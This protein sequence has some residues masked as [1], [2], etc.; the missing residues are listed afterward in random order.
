M[1]PYRQYLFFAFITR[2]AFAFSFATYVMFLLSKGATL[3]DVSFINISFMVAI[4]LSELPTGIF[5]DLLGR[6]RSFLISSLVMSAGLMIYFFSQSFWFFILAEVIAGIGMTFKS[7]AL[8]AWVVDAVAQ[9][10]GR[11]STEKIFSSG[12]IAENAANIVGGLAGAYMGQQNLAYPFLAGS[13]LLIVA[14]GLS[15]KLMI[16]PEPIAPAKIVSPFMAIKGIIDR[17]IK[18]GLKKKIVLLLMITTFM[19]SFFY[20][21]LNM[22]WQP[23]FAEMASGDIWIL[24]WIS[25][26]LMLGNYIIKKLP[27]SMPPNISLAI[28]SIFNSLPIILA[29]LFAKF[30]VVLILFCTYEVARGVTE[31]LRTAFLNRHIPSTER[32]TLLSLNQVFLRIGAV[33]GLY[34]TGLVADRLSIQAAWIVAS[35]VVLLTVPMFIACKEKR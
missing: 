17:S 1:K 32:A 19:T 26:S 31:P 34:I 20:Q 11:I 29:A 5:A 33:L 30:Y 8:E 23:R 13:I 3:L 4:A 28:S 6:K 14:F 35:L 7:G 25:L 10:K 12:A 27:E 2:M 16:E 24:G 15:A 18:H 21:P 22:Y 9:T